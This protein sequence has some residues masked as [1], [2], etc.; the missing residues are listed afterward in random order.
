MTSKTSGH[1]FCDQCDELAFGRFCQTCHEPARWVSHQS[2]DRK[3]SAETAADYFRQM[4]TTV[5][6]TPVSRI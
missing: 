6:A 1:Y 3:V 5:N 4:R 2:A